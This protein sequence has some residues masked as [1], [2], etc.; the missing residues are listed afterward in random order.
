MVMGRPKSSGDVMR[1]RGT[2]RFPAVGLKCPMGEVVDLS[3]T[4]L[5]A[6]SRGR[7]ELK[8]GDSVTLVVESESQQ[9]R[10]TGRAVWVK[11]AGWRSF[12]IGVQFVDVRPGIAAALGQL[13]QYGFVPSGGA[14][15]GYK[16]SAP[17]P[18]VRAVVE[19]EDLYT[20]FGVPRDANDDQIRETYHA[21]ARKYHPDVCTDTEAQDRFTLI[22]KAYSILRDPDRRQRYDQMLARA[23]RAA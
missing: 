16:A 19:I 9:I 17:P 13:A 22:S 18:K 1:P 12:E 8:P 4:G 10:V 23:N 6:R 2:E 11:R 5:R 14:A 7:P 3:V 20:I 15:A 21:L